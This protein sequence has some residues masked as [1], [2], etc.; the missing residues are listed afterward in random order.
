M[1]DYSCGNRFLVVQPSDEQLIYFQG[2]EAEAV[3][4]K[5]NHFTLTLK[6]A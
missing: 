5:S 4:R 6:M 1:L 2:A 3:A